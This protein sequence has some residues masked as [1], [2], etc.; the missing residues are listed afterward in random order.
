MA[1]NP[2]HFKWFTQ[3]EISTPKHGYEAVV[4]SWWETDEQGRVAVYRR[5]HPQ[6]NTDKRVTEIMLKKGIVP[7]AVDMAF[8]PVAFIPIDYRM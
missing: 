6:C 5:Y 7:G 3:E 2:D 8:L 4:D 1:I